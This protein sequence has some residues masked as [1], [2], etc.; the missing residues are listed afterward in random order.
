MATRRKK[1]PSS[2]EQDVLFKSKRRCALC[3]HLLGKSS[4]QIGQI[5]SLDVSAGNASEDNLVFLCLDH[6]AQYDSR[7]TR[8]KNFTVQEVRAAR[9]KLYAAVKKEESQYSAESS[10]PRAFEDKV[11]D[12]IREQFIERLGDHFALHRNTIYEGRS[13][14]AY[15]VD[16]ATRFSIGD[17]TFLTI[18]EVEY[19]RMLAT[20]S[21]ILEFIARMKDLGA[22]KGVFV[23]AAGLSTGAV[24]LA[25]ANG[26]SVIQQNPSS[27]AL[28]PVIA[29]DDG[30]EPD[31]QVR[32]K[33]GP[34]KDD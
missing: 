5:A 11:A 30:D 2:V 32:P 12:Y 13:G 4:P 8:G 15:E 28:E 24:R 14:V 16:I 3:F 25:R 29:K 26:I 22:D 6:H 27:G 10:D 31:I 19:R 1:I 9:S 17:L 18:F 7:W 20:P 23:S 34:R 21:D 33:S